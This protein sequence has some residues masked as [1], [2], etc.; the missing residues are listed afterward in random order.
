MNKREQV[1]K[2]LKALETPALKREL[3]KWKLTH[4]KNETLINLEKEEFQGDRVIFRD[5]MKE[6][7]QEVKAMNENLFIYIEIGQA[8]LMRR[9]V[10]SSRRPGRKK[11]AEVLKPNRLRD[12]QLNSST[13]F[14][15]YKNTTP[16]FYQE[17]FTEV[18]TKE[19]AELR[20]EAAF[21]HLSSKYAF[22][23]DALLN[24][25][26]NEPYKTEIFLEER[27]YTF[28][29]KTERFLDLSGAKEK[30]R[31]RLHDFLRQVFLGRE[32]FRA[33]VWLK[34]KHGD[35]RVSNLQMM[36]LRFVGKET[37]FIGLN[38]TVFKNVFNPKLKGGRGSFKIP[39]F[40]ERKLRDNCPG[41]YVP[42]IRPLYEYLD[43]EMTG[44]IGK[45][46]TTKTT[47]LVM[48]SIDYKRAFRDFDQGSIN[49]ARVREFL[50][51]A[52]PA[53]NGAGGIGGRLISY[54]MDKKT[55]SFQY[56]ISNSENSSPEN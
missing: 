49:K 1:K 46:S 25:Y 26:H 2:E 16:L 43:R 28:K 23:E 9:G 44:K 24:L 10:T 48:A 30:E 21:F 6:Y 34:D 29:V 39:N 32:A 41:R 36:G 51:K 38:E 7:I 5:D 54:S 18:T 3:K 20:N 55:L 17:N 52:V 4:K 45:E 14:E 40:L 27:H 37:L 56:K 47:G 8:E 11:Q 35:Y 42:Q 19:Q 31:E 33:V 50:E 22:L 15:W 53:I 12:L 13:L